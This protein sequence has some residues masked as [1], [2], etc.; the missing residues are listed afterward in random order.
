MQQTKRGIAPG[1][2]QARRGAS[3]FLFT[4]E[5]NHTLLEYVRSYGKMTRIL[6]THR[7]NVN[8]TRSKRSSRSMNSTRRGLLLINLGTPKSPSESDVRSF[9]QEFLS[10]PYV[11]DI[12]FVVRQLILHFAILPFRPRIAALA[13][14]KIW[15][16]RGSPL[17]FHTSDLTAK[18][19]RLLAPEFEVQFAMRYGKPFIPNVL[20]NLLRLNLER[21]IVIPLYPQYASSTTESTLS[22]IKNVVTRSKSSIPV[23]TVS[24]FHSN[25]DFISCFVSRGKHAIRNF[26]P[27]HVLFSFHGLPESHIRKIQP[28]QGACLSNN[29]SCCDA[30]SQSNANC[31]R[32]QCVHTARTIA[33]E[34]ALNQ[35]DYTI[36]FQSRLGPVP[37]IKPYTS[38]VI[39]QLAKRGK[40]KLLIFSPSFVADCVET[41]EEINIRG[42]ESF[43]AAGG[44]EFR[45]V[46]SLNSEDD[47][48]KALAKMAGQAA[49]PSEVQKLL[50]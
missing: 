2:P 49:C 16:A 19:A 15:T 13:Y 7:Y 40:K 47:W 9:L 24:P 44:K 50:I 29:F 32:A 41:L 3:T 37:W 26:T 5:L 35:T 39:P 42:K 23:Y 31:Y 18:V 34:L 14:Q 27:D 10:D 12:P 21:I 33:K 25:P 8:T 11:L 28:T 43:L 22:I 6:R 45:L 17:L 4:H 38:E 46:P 48:G 30:I 1:A 20:T 36:A